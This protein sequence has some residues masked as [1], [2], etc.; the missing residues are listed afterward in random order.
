MA[1]DAE[2][3]AVRTGSPAFVMKA[4][5]QSLIVSV[6]DVPSRAIYTLPSPPG[7]LPSSG[8]MLPTV[9]GEERRSHPEK[10]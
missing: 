1:P 7:S 4:A 5:D 6:A 8:K 3:R 10:D 9:V 2:W